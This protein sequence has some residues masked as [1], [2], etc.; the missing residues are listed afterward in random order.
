MAGA[1]MCLLA[2]AHGRAIVAE[3]AIVIYLSVL[4]VVVDV[5]VIDGSDSPSQY[6]LISPAT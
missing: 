3:M 5:R 4:L 6:D 2:Q 1:K